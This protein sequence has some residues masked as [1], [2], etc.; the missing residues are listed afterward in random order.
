MKHYGQAAARM[1][2]LVQSSTASDLRLTV[3][4]AWRDRWRRQAGLPRS[5]RSRQEGR[6]DLR[7]EFSADSFAQSMQG[8]LLV[9]KPGTLVFSAGYV[10]PAI[11][12]T[13]PL[14][15]DPELRQDKVTIQLPAS[16]KVDEMPDPVK[17]A[18]PFGQYDASWTLNGADLVFSQTLEVTP[19]LPRPPITPPPAP[20]SRA[21]LA[22]S[23]PRWS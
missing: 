17:L 5:R 12:R 9:L 1:R 8:R 14:V 20:S 19:S 15:L 3:E 21:S 22:P 11:Q 10:L 6:L 4:R 7:L 18:T 23:R 13:L 16:F 2:H